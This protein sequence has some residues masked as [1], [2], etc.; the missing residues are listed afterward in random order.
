MTYHFRRWHIGI[1]TAVAFCLSLGVIVWRTTFTDSR[2]T[3]ENFKKPNLD[4]TRSEVKQLLG[5]PMAVEATDKPN[6]TVLVWNAKDYTDSHILESRTKIVFAGERMVGR[7][8]VTDQEMKLSSKACWWVREV[9]T[10]PLSP[11]PP[12]KDV[13]TT[14]IE[15]PD[16]LRNVIS[17]ESIKAP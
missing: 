3:L 15:S 7:S 6:Q 1:L 14:L 9:T 8:V 10:H 2:V 13:R 4:W 16:L 5:P 17:V 12:A 11:S